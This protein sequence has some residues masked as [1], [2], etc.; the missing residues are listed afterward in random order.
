M[1]EE[2]KKNKYEC[3]TRECKICGSS[4]IEFCISRNMHCGLCQLRIEVERKK[5]GEKNV[6]D[7]L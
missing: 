2:Q 5:R 1:E 3:E 6:R 7:T 4:F